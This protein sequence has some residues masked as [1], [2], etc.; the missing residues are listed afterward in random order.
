MSSTFLRLSVRL[1]LQDLRFSGL[2]NCYVYVSSLC[3]NI[4]N[5]VLILLQKSMS[6]YGL[7][8]PVVIG[9]FRQSSGVGMTIQNMFNHAYYYGYSGAWSWQAVDNNWSN[10]KH[11]INYIR[12]KNDQAKGG[13]VHFSV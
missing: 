12:G 11:G 7:N 13:L 4:T 2:K 6:E 3:H 9:E 5:K 1:S 10:Q 8:K